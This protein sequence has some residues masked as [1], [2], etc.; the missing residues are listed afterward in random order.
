MSDPITTAALPCQEC[1]LPIPVE[2][3]YAARSRG[4]EPRYCS[5][6]CRTRAARKRYAEAK[7]IA[8]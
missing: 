2:R 7:R 6:V 5:V 4:G 8:K 3:I 1:S